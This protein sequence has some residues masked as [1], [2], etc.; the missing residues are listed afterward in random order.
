MASDT[1]PGMDFRQGNNF[2]VS[3]HCDSVEEAD[4]LFAAFGEKGKV[5]MPLQETSWA[6]RYGML[7]DQF[8][9]QWMFN[10]EHPPKA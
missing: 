8:G 7:R 3:I 4:A 5:V 6:A 9:I 10:L 1:L 2:S